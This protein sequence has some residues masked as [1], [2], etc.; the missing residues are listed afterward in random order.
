VEKGMKLDGGH[1][2]YSNITVRGNTFAM[3]AGSAAAF[4]DVG[5]TDGIVVQGNVMG[6]TGNSTG[7][8]GGGGALTDVRAYSSTGFDAAATKEGNTCGIGSQSRPCVV[9]Q[10]K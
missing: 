8:S 1:S 9:S 7:A 6:R 5:V 4:V 10:Q 3:G 2:I